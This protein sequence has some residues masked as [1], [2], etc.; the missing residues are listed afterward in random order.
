[1]TDYKFSGFQSRFVKEIEDKKK[2]VDRLVEN[3]STQISKE[4]RQ[5]DKLKDKI[6][7][8]ESSIKKLTDEAFKLKQSS[9]SNYQESLIT[10]IKE[11][12]IE[13]PWNGKIEYENGEP[14]GF[15]LTK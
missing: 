9:N 2:L 4:Q 12:G 8:L 7:L 15:L 13:P 3:I 14:V 5:L 6:F 1:M 11:L 10:I